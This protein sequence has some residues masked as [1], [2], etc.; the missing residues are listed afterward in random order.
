MIHCPQQTLLEVSREAQKL[1]FA[2]ATV[3]RCRLRADS[4][5]KLKNA[6]TGRQ[7]CALWSAYDGRSLRIALVVWSP[8]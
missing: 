5:E 3:E 4:V 1:G 8:T 6:T 2:G 7:L